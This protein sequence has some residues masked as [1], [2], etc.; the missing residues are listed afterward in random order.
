MH[1]HNQGTGGC[2]GTKVRKEKEGKR[3]GKAEREIEENA[4][5]KETEDELC[6]NVKISNGGIMKNE[7]IV[8][9]RQ[10]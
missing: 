4:R 2:R 7:R 6:G 10:K 8:E 1:E 9:K 5:Q 3:K